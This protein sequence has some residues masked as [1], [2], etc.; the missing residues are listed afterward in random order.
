MFSV[1]VGTRDDPI[2]NMTQVCVRMLRTVVNSLYTTQQTYV[3]AGHNFIYF[4]IS[5]RY[6]LFIVYYFFTIYY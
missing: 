6:I 2:C 1:V 4:L 3:I 5:N